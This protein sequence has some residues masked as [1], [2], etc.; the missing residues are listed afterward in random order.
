MFPLEEKDLVVLG[1]KEEGR[2]E[3]VGVLH[4]PSVPVHLCL[5]LQGVL[6]AGGA[7]GTRVTGARSLGW[8]PPHADVLPPS[9]QVNEDVMKGIY[10]LKLF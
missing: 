9:L 4:N 1:A 8:V 10:L 5:R 7:E 2:G 3:G 6:A